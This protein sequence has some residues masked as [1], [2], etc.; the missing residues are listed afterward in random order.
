MSR[1]GTEELEAFDWAAAALD[2]ASEAFTGCRDASLAGCSRTP[3]CTWSNA[4][5]LHNRLKKKCVQ[6]LLELLPGCTSP[7][8]WVQGEEVPGKMKESGLGYTLSGEKGGGWQHASQLRLMPAPACCLL[9]QP[10][11]GDKELGFSR[12]ASLFDA[13]NPPHNPC[14]TAHPGLPR[15]MFCSAGKPLDPNSA[16]ARAY[17]LKPEIFHQVTAGWQCPSCQSSLN[18]LAQAEVAHLLL[19]LLCRWSAQACCARGSTSPHSQ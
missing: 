4:E 12:L 6:R 5:P 17:G 19:P 1:R 16:A 7:L 3:V 10:G 8:P 11:C 2:G 9:G 14:S 13:S 15:C 18:S